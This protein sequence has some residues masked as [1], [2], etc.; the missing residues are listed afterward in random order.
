LSIYFTVLIDR[1]YDDNGKFRCV[2]I[3]KPRRALL[4]DHFLVGLYKH[5]L[6]ALLAVILERVSFFDL[7]QRKYVGNRILTVPNFTIL[8]KR[9]HEINSSAASVAVN[10]GGLSGLVDVG[11][12][13]CVV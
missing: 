12:E 1:I 3:V 5:E 13:F 8:V 4:E 2:V 9:S 6:I 10:G 7:C 11:Q